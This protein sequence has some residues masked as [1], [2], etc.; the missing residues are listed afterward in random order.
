VSLPNLSPLEICHHAHELAEGKGLFSPVPRLLQG[1]ESLNKKSR[2][3]DGCA[4]SASFMRLGRARI[5]VYS[6]PLGALDSPGL[7][8][9]PQEAR[10]IFQRSHW[11][12]ATET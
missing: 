1:S 7:T 9:L 3:P 8:L 10:Q 4:L 6:H 12:R 5:A 2:T 11:F